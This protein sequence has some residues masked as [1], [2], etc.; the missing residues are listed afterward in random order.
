LRGDF[1][2][3]FD[4]RTI[5]SGVVTNFDDK[6]FNEVTFRLALRYQVVDAVAIRGAAYRGFRAPTLANLYRS[7]GTTSFVGLSNPQL[8]PETLIGG[9]VGLDLQAKAAKLTV[10]LNGFYNV[11]NDFIA[12]V[13]VAFDPIFTTEN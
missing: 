3:N 12:G 8:E 1:F 7:F 13:A 10:Q 5:E 4:G 2:R 6:S 9:E 11:V